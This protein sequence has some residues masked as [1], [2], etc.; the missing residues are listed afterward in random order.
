MRPMS[1]ILRPQVSVLLQRQ[2]PKEVTLFQDFLDTWVKDRDRVCSTAMWWYQRAAQVW[3]VA[4]C[5]GLEA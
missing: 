5:S 1:F 2:L 4:T 3:F